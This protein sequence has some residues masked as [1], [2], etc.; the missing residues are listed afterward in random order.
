M[1]EYCS[2]YGIVIVTFIQS[3][4]VRN[5]ESVSLYVCKR[6]VYHGV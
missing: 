3:I 1:N 4:G 6:N 2:S 5:E